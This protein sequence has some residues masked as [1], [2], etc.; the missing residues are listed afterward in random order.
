MDPWAFIACGARLEASVR[1]PATKPVGKPDAG[2][3][4]VRFDERGWETG[5]SSKISTRAR[6][7]LY[8]RF[9]LLIS[10]AGRNRIPSRDPAS[11]LGVLA[12]GERILQYFRKCSRPE[13]SLEAS[14]SR[15][16]AWRFAASQG[17]ALWSRDPVLGL[18][19]GFSSREH[20][21]AILTG[22]TLLLF[23]TL[24]KEHDGTGR[25]VMFRKC[26]VR[27]PTLDSR[28]CLCLAF[29]SQSRSWLLQPRLS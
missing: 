23:S 29:I 8:R 7:R 1:E 19:P 27:R 17:P 18:S 16:P 12:R 4:H 26:R 20:S 21:G 28:S 9:P 2:N 5:R 25:V 11:P 15:C 3:P 10:S 13:R 14:R 6:P 22:E 24:S